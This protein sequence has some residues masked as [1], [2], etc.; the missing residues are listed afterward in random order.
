MGDGFEGFCADTSV[1]LVASGQSQYVEALA[2]C[3]NRAGTI[4]S[5]CPSADAASRLLELP[6][7]PFE[8][9]L[10]E[11]QDTGVQALSLVRTLRHRSPDCSVLVTT[12]VA[13]PT[14]LR[15]IYESG[16][17]FVSSRATE[18]ELMFAMLA[19]RGGAMPDLL[20][21]A[22]RA[23]RLWKLPPQQTRLLYYNLWG[24]SNQEIAEALEL[25]VHTVHEYQSD[26]R[27]R[28]GA[29]SKSEY[30]RVLLEHAGRLPC[31]RQQLPWG[32]DA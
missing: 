13:G 14:L 7:P 9:A 32:A 22:A 15:A 12:D 11:A 4:V 1:L 30:L 10:I 21:L 17:G 2:S 3:L 25:S 5:R 26:L 27:R 31:D 8:V 20:R 16:A 28:T 23:Q 24:Y 18:D 6:H 19:A 29:Q